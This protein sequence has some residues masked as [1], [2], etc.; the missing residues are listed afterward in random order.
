MNIQRIM[1]IL[2][3]VIVVASTAKQLISLHETRTFNAD[4]DEREK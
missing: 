3:F 1:M 4:E 2:N